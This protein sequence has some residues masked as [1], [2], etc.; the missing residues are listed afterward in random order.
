MS[1]VTMTSATANKMLRQLNDEKGYLLRI[2]EDA[3]TY[4]EAEGAEV[5]APEYDYKSTAKRIDELDHK[6]CILKHAINQMN[7]NTEIT[8]AIDDA[9]VTMT[10]DVA[11]V[12]MAQLNRRASTLDT[13]RKRLPKSRKEDRYGSTSNLVEYVCVNYDIEAVK[14]DYDAVMRT[15]T[16][17]QTQIDY[18]NQTVQFE[19]EGL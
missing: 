12:K 17:I 19:V 9:R 1:T 10:M 5:Y 4:I 11:L 13:M 18:V 8:V 6:V 7:I 16:E 3:S 15:I 2:E 14:A